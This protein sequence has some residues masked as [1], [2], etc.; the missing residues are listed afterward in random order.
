[1]STDGPKLPP[2]FQNGPIKGPQIK[3]PSIKPSTLTK[4]VAL[5]AVALFGLSIVS[6]SFVSV[7]ANEVG[8]E[9]VRGK[10]QGTLAP[11]WHLVSPIGGRVEK[12]STRLQQTSMLRNPN[13]G[14]RAGDDSIEAASAEGATLSVDLTVNY[15]LVRKDAVQLF[16][17]IKSENDLQERVV[18]PTVRSVTRDVFAQYNARDAITSKRSEIQQSIE[19]RLNERFEKQGIA[20]E[21]V[22]VRELYLPTNLQE[23]VNQ[24]IAAEAAAQKATIERKQKETEAETERL[25]AEKTAERLRISAQ[26]E[27]DA[28]KI[29]AQAE[30]AANASIAA[31][32][33]PGLIELRQIEAVYKN[34]NQIY[35]IP[36]GANPNVF[37]NPSGNVS[38]PA[39]A[40]TT[41][42][43]PPPS[44]P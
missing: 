34:G 36:Q 32:L 41:P 12:F 8:V 37:L 20:I 4:L 16:N 24:A 19:R 21:S 44:T 27:A 39:A 30:A 10:V 9:I 2:I 15:R 29:A 18:R 6:R 42:S 3:A 22:D 13:E 26:G 11:G 5:I 23:Q 28:L 17:T 25:V 33:T 43:A 35:F 40:A 31:S 7:D 1:M 14:D 38:A